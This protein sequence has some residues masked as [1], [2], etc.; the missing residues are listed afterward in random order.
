MIYQEVLVIVGIMVV[1]IWFGTR[2]DKK[3]KK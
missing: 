3:K 1:T 2:P